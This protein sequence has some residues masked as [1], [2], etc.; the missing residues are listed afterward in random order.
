MN[1]DVSIFLKANLKTLRKYQHGR[2]IDE[3]DRRILNVAQMEGVIHI[4]PRRKAMKDG[5]HR[6]EIMRASFVFIPAGWE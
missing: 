5:V 6:P 1:S 4:R 2:I 3:A